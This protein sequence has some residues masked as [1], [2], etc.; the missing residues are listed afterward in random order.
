MVITD[1][2]FFAI[3]TSPVSAISA[4]LFI[5]SHFELHSSNAELF[6]Q[7]LEFKMGKLSILD[8]V[9]S[10]P[11]QKDQADVRDFYPQRSKAIIHS[12]KLV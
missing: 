10:S 8:S 4:V 5:W 2:S 11:Q 9:L 6:T 1:T 7:K 12:Q 3:K